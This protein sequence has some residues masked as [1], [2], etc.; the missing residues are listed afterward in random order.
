MPDF[1]S[2]NASVGKIGSIE[3]FLET[4]PEIVKDEEII[5]EGVDTL[6]QEKITVPPVVAKEAD[7]DITIE[8]IVKSTVT[9]DETLPLVVDPKKEEEEEAIVPDVTSTKSE[10]VIDY[11]KVITSLAEK[12]I[13]DAIDVF[14]TDEGD[15]SFEDMEIDEK[16]FTDI[17]AQQ[18]EVVKEKAAKGKISL[19]GNSDFTKKLVEIEKNGGNIQDALKIY[20]EVQNP[21]ES[22]DLETDNGQQT[23]VYM[24]YKQ[25]GLSDEEALTFIKSYQ[26]SGVLEEKAKEFKVGM[27]ER[28][29]QDL[30]RINQEAT[31]RKQQHNEALKTYRTNLTETYKD[32]DLNPKFKNRLIDVA[33]KPNKE[34]QFE[35]DNLHNSV[36]KDASEVA[37]LTLYLTD[38]EAFYK[39]VTSKATNEKKLET[40]RKL[41]LTS[42]RTKSPVEIEARGQSKDSNYVDLGELG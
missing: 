10:V 35:L 12:G 13:W 7:A 34:G 15:I 27:E 42:K 3:S 8:P 6:L 11:K 20:Q 22:V 36:R 14:E 28:V 17:V 26:S 29:N 9:P 31:I 40:F 18:H 38:K 19:S 30:E 37:E 41:K 2:N 25:K 32:F 16:T 21:L 39:Y 1:S 4:T 23:V 24:H 33:T 5:P